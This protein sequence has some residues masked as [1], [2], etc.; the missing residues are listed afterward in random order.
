MN[1]ANV[2]LTRF[3]LRFAFCSALFALLW[4]PFSFAQEPGDIPEQSIRVDVNLVTL[5]FT[6]TAGGNLLNTLSREDFQIFED[7]VSQEVVF[8]DPPANTTGEVK[9]LRLAFLLDVSGSTL[10]TR[11][12]QIAAARTFLDNMHQFAEV[13]VFGFTDQLL[14]FQDFTPNRALALKALAEARRHIGRTAIYDSLNT[15]ISRLNTRSDKFERNVVIVISDGMDDGYRRSAQAIT[16]ARQ[17]NVAVYTILVPSA[18]Q[19]FVRPSPPEDPPSVGAESHLE[20]KAT[21]FA[22]LSLQTGG[23]HFSGFEAILGFDDVMAQISDDVFG[24]L[25]S[26]GYYTNDPYRDKSERSIRVEINH[27]TASIPARFENLP[28]R[29]T[30][31]KR[32]I[33]ALFSNEALANLPSNLHAGFH[34]IGA[35]IDLLPSR[36]QG[37]Q[38]G[39]PFRIKISPFSILS[40]DRAGV[41]TQLGI[42]GV[43][44]DETGNEVVRLREVVRISMEAKEIREGRGIIYTNKL[45]APPGTYA[46]KLAVLE[47]PTWRMTAFENVVRIRE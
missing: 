29:L 3:R 13:G 20:E 45:L 25:Y 34:E 24:N 1:S 33:A 5:R 28:E 39:L 40:P 38:T 8:F 22:R 19:L 15:L 14:I 23:K 42:I 46:F 32:F 9:P 31:K 35:E 26:L 2:R 17:N 7:G 44:L 18:T 11:G 27:P 47:I 36:Q 41:H 6:V 37:G 30:A 4:P 21:A 43:L 10:S 12:E 16:L